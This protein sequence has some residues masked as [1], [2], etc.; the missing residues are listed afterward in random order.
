MIRSR[1]GV[2][3]AIPPAGVHLFRVVGMNLG[4][5]CGDEDCLFPPISLRIRNSAG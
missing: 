2:T 5:A 4:S 3:S 1:L